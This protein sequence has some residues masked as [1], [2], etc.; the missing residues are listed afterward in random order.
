MAGNA[1]PRRGFLAARP[2][3]VRID[4]YQSPE[5]EAVAVEDSTKRRFYRR[6][7]A[8][9]LLATIGCLVCYS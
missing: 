8:T 7:G 5:H 1:T 6:L 2:L 4:H 3:T 9:T